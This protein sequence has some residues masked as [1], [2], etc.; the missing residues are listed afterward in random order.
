MKA[1]LVKELGGPEKLVYGD[2]EIGSPGAGRVKIE[3]KYAGVNF[4]DTLIIRGKY[5]FQPELPFSPGGEVAGIIK[6]V[7]PGVEGFKPGDRVI[8]GTTSGAF[9]EE[10]EGFAFN[11]HHLPKE[12]SFQDGATVLM[13]HGTVIHALKD[14]AKLQKGETL[15]IL[16]ASGGVGTAAIQLGK[17]MGANIIACASTDE[18]L[19]FC[20]E[21]GADILHKYT[22]D[23]IKSALKDLTGGKGA[24]VIFDAVGGDYSEQ[25]FRGIAPMGRFLVVGFASG[26]VPKIPLNLPLLKSASITGVFW[27]NFFRNFPEENKTNIQE[28]LE[29][30]KNRKINPIVD[31][32]FAL[33]DTRHALEKIERRQVKGKI[34]IQIS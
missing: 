6:E 9:A 8:S 25:A 33:S 28:L 14:R 20:K 23:N 34:I 10:A 22:P 19:E 2:H 18:K 4:P 5:Q 1:I 32:V 21:L 30:V 16:G 31:E 15:A 29:M 17:A 3:V 13:T 7:G 24:D 27:G 26:Y 12:V 11:T